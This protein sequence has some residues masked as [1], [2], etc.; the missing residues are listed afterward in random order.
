[1]CGP[2]DILDGNYFVSSTYAG[3][4]L[5]LRAL[6]KTIDIMVRRTDYR[7]EDLWG[8]GEAFLTEF[9]AIDKDVQIEGYPT[10]GRFIGNPDKKHLFFQEMCLAKHL[11][12]P[13]WFYNFPLVDY[14]DH[15][16][17]MV[18]DVFYKINSGAVKLEGQ[19]P[20]SPFAEVVRGSKR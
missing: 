8:A 2:K 4:I 18:K 12:G 16:I 1:V 11:F 10:R 9:N 19:A 7:I 5:S 6:T 20:Q 13:S 15:T 14:K 17:N 3:E